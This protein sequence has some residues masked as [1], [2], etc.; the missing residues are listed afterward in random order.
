MFQ[1]DL[2]AVQHIV[3]WGYAQIEIEYPPDPIRAPL[4]LIRGLADQKE[5]RQVI[6][7]SERQLRGT[8]AASVI[9]LEFQAAATPR[10]ARGRRQSS[11]AGAGGDVRP[12]T[13]DQDLHAEPEQAARE[14]FITLKVREQAGTA[15]N[16]GSF[17]L[18]FSCSRL[19]HR[20][21]VQKTIL[22]WT[23]QNIP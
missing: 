7:T 10:C 15:R 14:L 3:D 11:S 21:A 5:W 9:E 8:I 23:H 4:N 1:H 2:A 19:L 13:A 20:I 22:M 12:V 18:I 16:G 6:R 17:Y